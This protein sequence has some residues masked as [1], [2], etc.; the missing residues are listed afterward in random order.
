MKRKK[1]RNKTHAAMILLKGRAGGIIPLANS[2][3]VKK[4][5]DDLIAELISMERMYKEAFNNAL[6]EKGVATH[7]DVIKELVRL[8]KNKYKNR[9]NNDN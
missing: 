1:K 5:Y 4:K 2:N 7:D 8:K 9:T 3:D 6:K